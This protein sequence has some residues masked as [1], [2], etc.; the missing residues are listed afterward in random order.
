MPETQNTRKN[1][2]AAS[3]AYDASLAGL[4]DALE[5]RTA[6]GRV[7]AAGALRDACRA[8]RVADGALLANV[9]TAGTALARLV[10][11]GGTERAAALDAL[12]A[13]ALC[14]GP[15]R[16]L[17]AAALD[18]C[19]AARTG[20]ALRTAAL[21]CVACSEDHDTTQEAADT[22]DRVLAECAAAATAPAT[23]RKGTAA[24]VTADTLAGAV[25]AWTLLHSVV[26]TRTATFTAGA[27]ALWDILRHHCSAG[28][29]TTAG[30]SGEDLADALADALLLLEAECFPR[31]AAG[32]A[33]LAACVA[34]P[35]DVVAGVLAAVAARWPR[36]AAR[37]A[38]VREARGAD[39]AVLDER[40]RAL[41]PEVVLRRWRVAVRAGALLRA[42]Q[43]GGL[44]HH[45]RANA[46]VREMLDLP[47]E[48]VPEPE[49]RTRVVVD[50]SSAQAR[51]ATRL[52]TAQ[53]NA[54]AYSSSSFWSGDNDYDDD[55]D[56]F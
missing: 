24:T 37:V 11:R 12:A 7:A 21:V 35:A 31:A 47:A 41:P 43:P 27:R 22:V 42:L 13:V 1:R 16:G 8:C 23:A 15:A 50:P 46:V 10:R 25:A 29:T 49:P 14:A 40:A 52:R 17:C 32:L 44:A 54:K 38:C 48:C 56:D 3:K 19:W 30:G 34:A 20:P 55:D 36:C 18:A 51:R 2:A 4:L 45:V 26:E 53:R 6:R 28:A 9:E 33:G 5:G 39:A